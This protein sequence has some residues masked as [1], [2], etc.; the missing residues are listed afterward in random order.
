MRKIRG[1]QP[2]AANVQASQEVNTNLN[3][4]MQ[5]KKS[6]EGEISKVFKFTDYISPS[7]VVSGIQ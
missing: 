3:V 5:L 2:M 1:S 4:S 7:T 6:P